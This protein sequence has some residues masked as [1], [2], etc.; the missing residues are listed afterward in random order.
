M[1]GLAVVLC[2]PQCEKLWLSRYSKVVYFRSLYL[3]LK[4]SL[5]VGI[6]GQQGYVHCESEYSTKLRGEMFE[7]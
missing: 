2:L 5:S 7:P 4:F 3:V 1:V 6:A